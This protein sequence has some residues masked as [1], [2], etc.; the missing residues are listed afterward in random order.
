MAIL[1]QVIYSMIHNFINFHLMFK[2]Q[3]GMKMK[4]NKLFIPTIFN[5]LAITSSNFH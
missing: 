5:A 2:I 3:I 4:L 1:L